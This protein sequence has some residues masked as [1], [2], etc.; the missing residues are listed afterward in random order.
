MT[1]FPQAQFQTWFMTVS[2]TG[3]APSLTISS[4]HVWI[5]WAMILVAGP[6]SFLQPSLNGS[7]LRVFGQGSAEE[8]N[9]QNIYTHIEG[10]LLW[11]IGS[12]DNGGWE[13]LQSAVWKLENQKVGVQFQSRHEGLSQ[14]HKSQSEGW[15]PGVPMSE[16]RR[17]ISQLCREQ[18][19][20][21][22]LD[23][24]YVASLY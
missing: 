2:V 9:Q 24:L 3:P 12:H 19:W 4:H 21:F 22:L 7:P 5:L 13:V 11:V 10:D 15:E 18:I 23:G 16:C 8:Q 20:V 14:W 6:V 17:W 1:C